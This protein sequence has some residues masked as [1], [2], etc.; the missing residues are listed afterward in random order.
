[1]HAR[2]ADGRGRLDDVAHLPLVP[3]LAPGRDGGAAVQLPEAASGGGGR[4]AGWGCCLKR[5]NG[6]PDWPCRGGAFAG[7]YRSEPLVMPSSM[8]HTLLWLT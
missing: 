4:K 2:Q 1:M 3:P 6:E 7:P 8:Q 5:G